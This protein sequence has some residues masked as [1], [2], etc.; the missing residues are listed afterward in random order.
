MKNRVKFFFYIVVIFF[1]NNIIAQQDIT[2]KIRDLRITQCVVGYYL[3]N[4]AKQLAILPVDTLSG[5]IR[6]QPSGDLQEGIYF[7]QN[8]EGGNILDFVVEKSENNNTFTLT[9]E[10][11]YFNP[12]DS[13]RVFRSEINQLYY[14]Y[15]KQNRKILVDIKNIRE[16]LSRLREMTTEADILEKQ[17]QFLQNKLQALDSLSLVFQQ[18]KP[19]SLF[20][21]VLRANTPPSV[22]AHLKPITADKKP[23]PLYLHFYRQHFF[24]NIDFSDERL[25]RTKVY[26]AQLSR[27]FLQILT[28]NTD[29]IK[30]ATENLLSKLRPNKAFFN[31]T[32]RRLLV[33]FDVT[34]KNEA[35]LT[36]IPD[37][38]AIVVQLV[39]T[40]ASDLVEATDLAIAERAKYRANLLRPTL[41]GAKFPT[42]TL[43]KVDNNMP[44]NLEM[45][46]D[47][48]TLMVFY[49]PD[50]SHCKIALPYIENAFNTFKNKGLN[51]YSV[52]NAPR[53]VAQDFIKSRSD[54]A[55]WEQVYPNSMDAQKIFNGYSLPV[56]FLLDKDKKVIAKRIKGDQLSNILEKFIK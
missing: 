8:I 13:A 32:L 14:D 46:T 31:Y 2:F 24:D 3:G 20:S 41:L 49:D 47:K 56:M 48:F 44:L 51:I 30:Q 26:D 16:A 22:H 27:Y 11:T 28:P 38:D 10:T 40:Y 7:L 9:L 37:P 35:S 52:V 55:T 18:K 6:F 34:D 42:L 29:S 36:R 1:A 21:K 25:L 45:L 17:N 12:I 23:N 50:C 33:L 54:M 5:N 43:P 4:E 19:N 39:D 15:M 53:E